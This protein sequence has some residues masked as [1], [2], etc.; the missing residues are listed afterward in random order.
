MFFTREDIDKIYQGLLARG[1]KD[2]EF[3]ETNGVKVDD[4]L[5]IIQDGENKQINVRE[6]LDQISLWKKESF[7][8]ITDTYNKSN[9]TLVEAIQT[10]PIIQRKEGLVITFSDNEN[11]WR[12]YQFRDDLSQFSNEDLWVD[13]YDF[14]PYIKGLEKRVEELEKKVQQL[15]NQLTAE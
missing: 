13:L 1:I 11:N 14:T 10:V 4:T 12:I 15:I 2:S 8:N 5:A 3:P 7:I 6:F 9:I